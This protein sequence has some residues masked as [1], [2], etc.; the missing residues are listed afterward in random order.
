MPDKILAQ[1][2]TDAERAA[3]HSLAEMFSLKEDRDT[4]RELVK[5]G[6]TIKDLVFAYKYQKTSWRLAKWVAGFITIVGGAVATYA[7]LT[8]KGV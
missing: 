6:V 1:A 4:L 5:S 8:G 3:L 7:K 2:F